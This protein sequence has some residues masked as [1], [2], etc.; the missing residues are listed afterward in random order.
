MKDFLLKKIRYYLA[1]HLLLFSTYV[2][3]AQDFRVQGKVTDQEGEAIPG[4]AVMA[5]G[6]ST[7]AVTDFN[8]NYSI[9]MAGP[10][11]TL[12]FSFVGFQTQEVPVNNRST[13]DVQLEG[14]IKSLEEVVVVGY[15][16]QLK[17]EVTGSVQAVSA[18]ELKDIPVASVTQKLQGRLAG[19]Q[20]NQTTGKPGQ[21]MSVRIRGQLSV[22]GGSDPLYV[23]DGFPITGGIGDINPDEIET[24]TILKDAA[25]TSLYGSRAANGVVLITTRQA[26]PGQTNVSFN[27]YV[28]LQAVPER[29]RLDMMDAVEFAQF[30]KEYYED[31]GQ[32]V[33]E[34]FQDPSRYEGQTN[35]WYGAL[36]RKAP[37]QSYNL[38]ITSSKDKINTSL[39]AGVFNQQGVVLN[40]GYKRYSL[41]MN[42]DYKVSDK[43]RIGFNVAP[44]YIKDN[45]P[46][47]DGDRGTGIL[48]N[49]LHTW[50]IMPIYDDNGELT[51]YN[52][53]P[54]ETG[55]IFAYANWLRSAQELINETT[56]LNLL[57][58]A[59]MEFSPIKD[60][61]LRSTFNAELSASN[62]FFFNPSTATS[63]I[64]TPIP[65]TAVSALPV[66]AAQQGRGKL[67][68][69]CKR[70]HTDRGQWKIFTYQPEI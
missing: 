64:N 41:R 53:F 61:K 52:K 2:V 12:V 56:S 37:I 33:P 57:S 62:F 34:V 19:V 69:A 45:I 48:F 16:S 49:A 27:S 46:R 29:G 24:I 18:E 58:N 65:T 1:L 30:K 54:A 26:K 11:G 63:N 55:N 40:S 38:T 10:D 39:V 32:P 4:V 20:I 44:S 43:V 68:Y 42:T 70:D 47:T 59:Y 22:T 21:G 7:G 6:T 13:I 66:D 9:N 8:G 25:S 5:K 28:G 17:A 14:D 23:I 36:L 60:L 51:L 67:R 3:L 50:P 15:G 31:A 35:D